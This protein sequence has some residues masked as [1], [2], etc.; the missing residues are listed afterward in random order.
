MTN[1]HMDWPRSCSDTLPSGCIRSKVEDFQVNEIPVLSPSGEGEHLWIKL[2]KRQLN[3]MTVARELTQAANVPASSVSFAGLKD[4]HAVTTQWFSIWLPGQDL[5]LDSSQLSQNIEIIEQIRHEKKLK[6]GMLKGNSFTIIIRQFK[7]NKD[8]LQQ[9][10]DNL[11]EFGVPNYFGQQRFG[12][13]GSNLRQVAAVLSGDMKIKGRQQRSILYSTMRSWLFNQILAARIRQHTWL[14][15]IQGDVFML[16]GSHS[17]FVD[18]GGAAESAAKSAAKYNNRLVSG[19]IHLTAPLYG[20]GSTMAVAE[21]AKFEQSVIDQYPEMTDFLEARGL[22]MSRR[23]LRLL[24]KTIE[25]CWL[26]ENVVELKFSLPAGGYATS[27]LTEL[28]NF[29]EFDFKNQ[30]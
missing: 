13:Q 17:L 20:A 16:D 26:E 30:R 4:K 2:K 11:R 27:V 23:A 7:G 18:D 29:K 8:C 3:T 19:D 1:Y 5:T 10:L 28:F 14:T 25:M 24:P 9:R 15:H 6:R 12:N 21:A 22:K